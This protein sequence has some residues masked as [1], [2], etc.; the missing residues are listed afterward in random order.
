MSDI[1]NG[2]FQAPIEPR[3]VGAVQIVL[4]ENG[5]VQAKSSLPPIETFQAI[6]IA[7]AK[8]AAIFKQKEQR[9]IVT[10]PGVPLPNLRG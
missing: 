7:Q 1:P 8:L 2:V 10:P 3:V 5:D 9:P 6:G 4:L